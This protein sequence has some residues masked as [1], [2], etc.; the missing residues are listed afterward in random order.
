MGS[1]PKYDGNPCVSCGETLRYVSNKSCVRCQIEK[2]KERQKRRTAKAQA[3]KKTVQTARRCKR[4][5]ILLEHVA[6]LDCGKLCGDCSGKVQRF[7][8]VAPV[9]PLDKVGLW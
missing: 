3:Y 4:C 1:A 8:D 5:G 9:T 6:T 2:A 7:R